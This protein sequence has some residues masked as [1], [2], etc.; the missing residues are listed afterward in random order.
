M[1]ITF[2]A[3]PDLETAPIQE[4]SVLFHPKTAKFIM[5]NQ[6][7]ALLWTELSTP[8]T[9]DELVRLLSAAFRDPVTAGQDVGSL[10]ERLKELDLVSNGG[11]EAADT[12]T[13]T[14]QASGNNGGSEHPP[15]YQ[16]PSLRVLDEEELLEIFQM[17][18][19]EI[20]LAAC[21]WSPC[22]VGCP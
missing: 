22:S 19:A 10:L 15:A 9:E 14:L 18:A 16:P 20:S 13:P 7:A 21:W 3:A 2:V 8:R 5:L 4:G 11:A 6:S 12:P 1:S 17:T